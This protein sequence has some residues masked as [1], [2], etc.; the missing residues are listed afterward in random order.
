[1]TVSLHSRLWSR[2]FS[3]R[4]RSRSDCWRRGNWS[5]GI[6]SSRMAVRATMRGRNILARHGI[7]I[8]AVIQERGWHKD[9]LPFVITLE[10]AMER[11]VEAALDEMKSLHRV[12]LTVR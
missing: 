9:H 3:G 4:S 8:D 1:M 11:S 12:L 2:S 6:S 10:P 7:N 5:F